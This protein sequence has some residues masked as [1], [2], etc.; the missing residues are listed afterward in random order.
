MAETTA[1]ELQIQLQRIN[2]RIAM[3][4][5]EKPSTPDVRVDLHDE[6]LQDVMKAAKLELSII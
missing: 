4:S 6:W 1:Y 2:E 5:N 3:L